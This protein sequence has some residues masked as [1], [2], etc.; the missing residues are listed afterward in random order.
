MQTGRMT[1]NLDMSVTETGKVR[2]QPLV[3]LAEVCE[4]MIVTCCI[5]S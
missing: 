1:G 2:P 3:T 5:L 4:R